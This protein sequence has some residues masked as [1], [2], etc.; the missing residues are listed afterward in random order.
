MEVLVRKILGFAIIFALAACGNSQPPASAA[1]LSLRN[2]FNDQLK[3][4]AHYAEDNP[5]RCSP[6]VKPPCGDQKLINAADEARKDAEPAMAAAESMAQAADAHTANA[7]APAPDPAAM[8]AQV[9]LA[10]AKVDAFSKI[11]AQMVAAQ[12]AGSAN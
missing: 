9:A 5:A 6:T 2:A 12:K 3:I 4:A 8:T 11:V 10:K 7:L 1:A